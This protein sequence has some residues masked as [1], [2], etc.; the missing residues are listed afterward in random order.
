[1]GVAMGVGVGVGN[2]RE[3]QGR[4]DESILFTETQ[5]AMHKSGENKFMARA[6]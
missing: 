6:G 2:G 5:Y 1:M 4:R 3:L